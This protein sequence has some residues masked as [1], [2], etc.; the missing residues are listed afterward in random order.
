MIR[1]RISVALFGLLVAVVWCNTSL[2]AEATFSDGDF[3]NWLFTV[4][5]DRPD[6]AAGDLMDFDGNPGWN[7][8]VTLDI[9]DPVAYC[10]AWC[11]GRNDEVAWTPTADGTITSLAMQ[12]DVNKMIN[13]EE[14]KLLVYQDDSYY[15]APAAASP[16]NDGEPDQW[17]RVT[18]GPFT[19]DQFVRMDG[20]NDTTWNPNAHPDFGS[21]FPL[22]FGFAA[23]GNT[24][25]FEDVWAVARYDNWQVTVEHQ[26]VPEPSA[27]ALAFIGGLALLAFRPRRHRRTN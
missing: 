23:G 16:I 7:L 19:A 14:L 24:E 4:E 5:S 17:H 21:G 10:G 11:L 12:I 27:L 13:V 25:A 9:D 8:W 1:A 22:K 26:P 3:T 2:A 18:W 20:A 6:E 15:L